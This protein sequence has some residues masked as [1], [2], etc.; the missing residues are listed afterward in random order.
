MHF[1]AFYTV[2]PVFL[3]T[4]LA[5][6]AIWQKAL[7]TNVGPGAF[8]M[9]LVTLKTGDACP[10]VAWVQQFICPTFWKVLPR[11]YALIKHQCC[12]M[13]SPKCYFSHSRGTASRLEAAF[14]HSLLNRRWPLCI[15]Y[16]SSYS[17]QLG[18]YQF[19]LGSVET[20]MQR[21]LNWKYGKCPCS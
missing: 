12:A 18:V 17:R 21:H 15:I 11:H 8:G 10:L 13:R 6:R 20:S 9:A 5:E 1:V 7:K 19:I 3:K 2:S 4:Y 14:D 16:M